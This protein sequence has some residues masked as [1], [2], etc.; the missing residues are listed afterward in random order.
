MFSTVGANGGNYIAGVT[1]FLAIRNRRVSD[2]LLHECRY[3][4][5]RESGDR[6]KPFSGELPNLSS[7]KP[8]TAATR[9][10]DCLKVANTTNVSNRW[11]FAPENGQT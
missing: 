5:A 10:G 6:E 11:R 4:E 1:A 3:V 2:T 9:I 8:K 7:R